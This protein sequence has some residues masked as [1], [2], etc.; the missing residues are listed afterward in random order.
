MM[1]NMM[2]ILFGGS[3]SAL[4]FLLRINETTTIDELREIK[5][6]L[7]SN[8]NPKMRKA[9]FNSMIVIDDAIASRYFR[10]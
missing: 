1:R 8:K 9:I 7:L 5:K 2:M 4:R 3:F 6:E 10:F